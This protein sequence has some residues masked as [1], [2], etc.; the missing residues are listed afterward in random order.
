[1]IPYF[2]ILCDIHGSHV[3][4]RYARSIT[5]GQLLLPL[6]LFLG[7]ATEFA[8]QLFVKRL[9]RC[10]VIDDTADGGTL[11]SREIRV[12]RERFENRVA[13]T[14]PHEKSAN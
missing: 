9:S 14:K 6:S 7:V 13:P 1:M 2:D 12:L 8:W 4:K 3:K 10:N 11:E 5:L